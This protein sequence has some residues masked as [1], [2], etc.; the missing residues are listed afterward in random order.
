MARFA[1]VYDGRTIDTY[2]ALTT[3]LVNKQQPHTTVVHEVVGKPNQVQHLGRGAKRIEIR[4]ECFADDAE[5][6]DKLT[7][8]I[9]VTTPR[10]QGQ[11]VVADTDTDPM[12]KEFNDDRVF[13]YQLSLI[14]VTEG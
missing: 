13:S 1:P 4:G 9:S 14:E 8:E 7:G 5:F 2:G 3:P 12:Q 6:I 11:A 10:F